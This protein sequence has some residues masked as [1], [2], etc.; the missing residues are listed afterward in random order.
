M[1]PILH[2]FLCRTSS[3]LSQAQRFQQSLDVESGDEPIPM[4][5]PRV[6]KPLAIRQFA[7]RA[8]VREPQ[9]SRDRVALVRSSRWSGRVVED[10]P[11][12]GDRKSTQAVQRQKGVIDAAEAG[13]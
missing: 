2:N 6:R 12:D 3:Q 7:K 11:Q 13:T 4:S 1:A 8:D 5:R 10:Q 9:D